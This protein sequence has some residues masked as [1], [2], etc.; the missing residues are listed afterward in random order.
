VVPVLLLPVVVPLVVPVLVV[1]P[2][3]VPLVLVPSVPVDVVVVVVVVVSVP[4]EPV[5]VEVAAALL[6]P[7]VE[8]AVTVF[9]EPVLPSRQAVRRGIPN[10]TDHRW[11]DFIRALSLGLRRPHR[12]SLC[13]KGALAPPWA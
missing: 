9:T 2:V 11:L 7:P 12:D 10:R 6:W 8:P 3:L 1:L 5:L 4:V 13:H